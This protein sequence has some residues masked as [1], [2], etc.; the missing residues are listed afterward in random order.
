MLSRRPT[1]WGEMGLAALVGGLVVAAVFALFPVSSRRVGGAAV[2]APVAAPRAGE[3]AKLRRLS[4]AA[5]LSAREERALVAA[6]GEARAS[7]NAALAYFE[8]LEEDDGDV[9]AVQ[10]QHAAELEAI[11]QAVITTRLAVDLDHA[12]AQA[13]E[14]QLRPLVDWLALDAPPP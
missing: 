2:N 10:P 14:R 12:R 1:P 7:G 11:V 6:L 13:L 9:A 5:H 8:G 3:Q 4:I